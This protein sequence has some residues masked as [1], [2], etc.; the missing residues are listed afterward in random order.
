MAY[1]V[2]ALGRGWGSRRK[3]KCAHHFLSDSATHTTR[4]YADYQPYL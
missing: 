4:H 2:C 3:E 1:N